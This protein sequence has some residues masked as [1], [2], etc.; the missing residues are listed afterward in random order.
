[1]ERA[2][3]HQGSGFCATGAAVTAGAA[4]FGDLVNSLGHALYDVTGEVVLTPDPGYRV[5]L[6]SFDVGFL[7]SATGC[8]SSLRDAVLVL[9][10]S[11]A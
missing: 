6:D 9:P 2:D 11:L 8:S 10:A 1:M 3:C 7:E 5:I 4:G